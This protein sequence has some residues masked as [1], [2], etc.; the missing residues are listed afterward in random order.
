MPFNAPIATGRAKVQEVWTQ[1]MAKPAPSPAGP[2]SGCADSETGI[3]DFLSC[4]L[5]LCFDKTFRINRGYNPKFL[6]VAENDHIHN[7]CTV[8]KRFC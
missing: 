1:L 5:V 7:G 2:C 6:I 8:Y 4:C 3:K